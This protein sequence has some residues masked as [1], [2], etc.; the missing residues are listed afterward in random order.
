MVPKYASLIGTTLHSF[1]EDRI[2]YGFKAIKGD[3]RAAQLELLKANVPA[4]VINYIDFDNMYENLMAYINDCIGYKMQPEVIL[5]LSEVCF[6]TADAIS[7]N[8]KTGM[9]RIHD[10]K[11]G[12]TPAH[13]EQL[14]IYAALFFL[15]YRAFKISE[16]QIELRIYQN[17]D[18]FIANP[19][20]DEIL[21]IMDKLRSLSDYVL[22]IQGGQ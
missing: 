21:P 14:L 3:K 4:A 17:N 16:S 1:A 6:G 10:L 12:S 15:E 9:L 2:R 11:T 19:G 7:F 18:V 20:V 22:N 8:E 5:Y 13:M